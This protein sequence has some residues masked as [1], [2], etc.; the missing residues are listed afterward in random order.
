MDIESLLKAPHVLSVADFEGAQ[1]L[2]VGVHDLG[3]E[4]LKA[5]V[6]ALIDHRSERDFGRICVAMEHRLR[7]KAGT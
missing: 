6:A 4:D 7:A 3:V 2:Q 5:E 1:R